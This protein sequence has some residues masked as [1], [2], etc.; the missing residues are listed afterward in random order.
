MAEES[1]E[2]EKRHRGTLPLLH[3]QE[4]GGEFEQGLIVNERVSSE[5]DW[6]FGLRRVEGTPVRWP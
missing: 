4:A 6:R 3:Y 5:R 2:S 1:P